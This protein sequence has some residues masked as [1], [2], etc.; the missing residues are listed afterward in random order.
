MVLALA[1]LTFVAG[2]IF[3]LAT[4]WLLVTRLER[5]AERL[6]VSEALLGV[7][8][9]LAADTPEITSS[10]SAISQHQRAIGAGVIVGSNVFNL[11]A[12]LGLGALAAG[13]IAFH[14]RVVVLGG[15][16]A[17]WVAVWCVV[18]SIGLV[19]APVGLLFASLVLVGYFIVLGLRRNV[20]EHLPLP[21]GFA[22]WLAL[23]VNDEEVELETSIRP[24]RGRPVDAIVAAGALILVVA[25]SIAM[26]R[27][28]SRLGH[29]F[30]VADAVVG[31]V[32][33]LG[34]SR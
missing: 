4:S 13:F 12:L 6:G 16:V 5:V 25:A 14:R 7:I 30:H 22:S 17:L 2:A 27:A 1:F 32:W 10:I 11:A 34:W 18:T 8:A 19:P 26:E 28:A 31:G 9:A 21:G 23:A 29:H 15:F 20:L 24:I 33:I 3:S